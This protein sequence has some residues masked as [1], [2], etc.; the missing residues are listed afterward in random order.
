MRSKR[1]K[2]M[3]IQSNLA[4]GQRWSAIFCATGAWGGNSIEHVR[5][6][7]IILPC[8]DHLRFTN[9]WTCPPE[10]KFLRIWIWN[11]IYVEISFSGYYKLSEPKK[12]AISSSIHE[13]EKLKQYIPYEFSKFRGKKVGFKQKLEFFK[14]W[15]FIHFIESY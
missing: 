1:K 15:F 13:G 4:M 6:K 12:A 10:S 11:L 14:I 8:E 9:N 5:V 2:T 3:F 7:L